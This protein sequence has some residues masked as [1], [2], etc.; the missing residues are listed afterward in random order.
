MKQKTTVKIKQVWGNIEATITNDLDKPLFFWINFYVNGVNVL[1]KGG[2]TVPI[3]SESSIIA[4]KEELVKNASARGITLSLGANLQ[5]NVDW[6]ITEPSGNYRTE[7]SNVITYQTLVIPTEVIAIGGV[8]SLLGIGVAIY[9][10]R[11]KKK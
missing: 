8:L 6:R 2:L 9:F 5:C 11:K 4:N 3:N 10:M 7:N 1:T